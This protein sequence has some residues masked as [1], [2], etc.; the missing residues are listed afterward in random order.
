[1]PDVEIRFLGDAEDA[2]AAALDLEAALASIRE[3]AESVTRALNNV[4][5]APSTV[6]RFVAE[7]AVMEEALASIEDQADDLR[8]SLAGIALESTI[9]SL[10]GAAATGRP[11][12]SRTWSAP[13]GGAPGT[14]L[15]RYNPVSQLLLDRVFAPTGTYPAQAA[16]YPYGP[17]A[18]RNKANAAEAERVAYVAAMTK[19]LGRGPGDYYM[20]AGSYKFTPDQMTPLRRGAYWN[21]MAGYGSSAAQGGGGGG[22][23][24]SDEAA[25]SLMDAMGWGHGGGGGGGNRALMM[26]GWAGY[27]GRLFGGLPTAR[28]GTPLA[29]MG[30]DAM[31][32]AG[33][34]LGIAGSAVGGLGIGGGLFG[35]GLGG[36]A[37]VG[38]GTDAAGIGQAAGDIKNVS[39][40]VDALDK[41]TALYGKDSTQAKDATQQLQFT[42][43]GFSAVARGA[44][45]QAT[46]AKGAFKSMFDRF[47]GPAERTGAQIITQGITT[48]GAF[49]PTLGRFA[50]ENLKIT[51]SG[52][53]PL[54]AWMQKGGT[55]QGAGG[56]GIFTQ[57]E[58]IF[59]N[60]LP[61]SVHAGVQAFELFSHAVLDA[62]NRTGNLLPKIDAFLTKFNTPTGLKAMDT[63]IGHMM[64]LFRSW[65]GLIVNVAHTLFDLFAPAVSLGQDF[66]DQISRIITKFRQWLELGSTQSALHSLFEAHRAQ[67]DAI[68]SILAQLIP[69]AEAFL[70]TLVRVE[71][72]MANF[73]IGP[74]KLIADILEAINHIPFAAT[75]LGWAGAMLIVYRGANALFV[76]IEAGAAAST[77]AV[78]TETVAYEQLA[79]AIGEANAAQSLGGRSSLLGALGAGGI[80]TRAAGM[81]ATLMG[82]LSRV[83]PFA[84]VGLLA[85]SVASS[86]ISPHAGNPAQQRFVSNALTFGGLGA[87]IGT[88]IAPG[89]GTA[90]GGAAGVGVAGIIS[91]VSL[92]GRN[93]GTSA[94]GVAA[95]GRAAQQAAADMRH[96]SQTIKATKFNLSQDKVALNQGASQVA[97]D[98]AAVRTTK[99][100]SVQRVMARDTLRADQAMYA[101]TLQRVT[102]EERTLE[103][104][105][106]KHAVAAQHLAQVNRHLYAEAGNVANAMR[107]EAV[108][109]NDLLKYVPALGR[110]AN[111]A[112]VKA[113]KFA[114][115]MNS[116]GKSLEDTKPKIAAVYE[117]LATLATKLGHIPSMKA[118]DIFLRIHTSASASKGPAGPLG[119]YGPAQAARDAA[120]TAAQQAEKAANDAA[121]SSLGDLGNVGSGSG[122]GGGGGGGG[123]AS[124]PTLPAALQGAIDA[125]ATTRGMHDDLAAVKAAT[126]W[127]QAKIKTLVATH[128]SLATLDP[129]YQMLSGLQGQM[130]GLGSGTWSAL[131]G[132]F[133]TTYGQATDPGTQLANAQ[134]TLRRDRMALQLDKAQSNVLG[135]KPD[136]SMALK[137]LNDVGNVLSSPGGKKLPYTQQQIDNWLALWGDYYASKGMSPL[138]MYHAFNKLLRENHLPEIDNPFSTGKLPLPP[139]VGSDE[140]AAAKAPLHPRHPHHRIHHHHPAHKINQQHSAARYSPTSSVSSTNTEAPTVNLEI[141]LEHGMEWLEQFVTVKIDGKE[142]KKGRAT[143][144]RARSGRY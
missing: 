99:P 49:L 143:N 32:M 96:A 117:G 82:G 77:A 1:M 4:E 17:W 129:Y 135:G 107:H 3:L 40:S 63:L 121:N 25:M 128:A 88:A 86:V 101:Q 87:G 133:D 102:Q 126:A 64:G 69:S 27:F 13:Q 71:T 84:M 16:P 132:Q 10:I 47:T 15:E 57:L 124:T 90:I 80:A 18:D 123:G 42:L 110:N 58:Q 53:Q 6:T 34:T 114:D 2:E 118:I 103:T 113:A 22:M 105:Q 70:M 89:I 120:N 125:A 81:R 43:S 51:Q 31:R 37:A 35:L 20:P 61:Q 68:F 9:G 112:S 7:A 60:R 138:E 142:V 108:S 19:M 28:F 130:G 139:G 21:D 54:F 116:S 55:G 72:V 23:S 73:T 39:K 29:L 12:G 140:R 85:G 48:G 74:L 137:I 67:M 8:R 131:T 41:A 52:L 83:A 65:A 115:N 94:T 91:L 14:A 50:S 36:T 100:G 62:A 26:P 122:G 45:L 76:R 141:N 92:L 24:P 134:A 97:A 46:M 56:L 33:S 30:L 127:V 136:N 66:A 5:I 59:Q 78:R 93:S 109:T 75:L 95:L 38:M 104:A 119:P 111:E 44:V 98:R 79:L 144:H 106:Q 11:V